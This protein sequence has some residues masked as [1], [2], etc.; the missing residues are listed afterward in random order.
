MTAIDDIEAQAKREL[1]AIERGMRVFIKHGQKTIDAT[2]D[3]VQRLTDLVERVQTGAGDRIGIRG[4]IA[5]SA[6]LPYFSLIAR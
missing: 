2:S 5:H 4:I 1:G 3:E 6:D